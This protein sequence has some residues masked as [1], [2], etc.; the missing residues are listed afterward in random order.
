VNA[1]ANAPLGEVLREWQGLGYDRR[2]KFLWQAAGMI[3]AKYGGEVPR[4]QA[5]L[6]KLPGVGVNTAGAIMAYAYNHPVQF[7]E[8]NIRTVYI[9]H[10]FRDERGI[11]DAQI[12]GKLRAMLPAD[13]PR[14]FYWA[15][16]DYG[17]DL[18]QRGY[19]LNK[20]SNKYAKQSQ[21]TGSRRQL[22]GQVLRIL[23]E[24]Q[25]SIDTLQVMLPDPRLPEVLEALLSEHLIQKT[26]DHYHL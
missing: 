3:Q 22:H 11:T 16:M 18:K 26:K 20:L 4:S 19:K 12:L 8:T 17:T 5:E 23:G 14:G 6:I 1:L 13:N 10:F 15:L 25:R 24:A 21:F 7:V 9:Y 2:A